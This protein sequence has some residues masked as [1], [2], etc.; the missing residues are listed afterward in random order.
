MTPWRAA[1]VVAL[2]VACGTNAPEI[3]PELLEP[4]PASCGSPYYPEGP[5]GT[6]V[7]EVAADVCFQGWERPGEVTH[8]ADTLTSLSFGRY[9]DP[10][11]ERYELLLVNS[12]ALWCMACQVEHE[13]LPARY[14]EYAPRGVVILSALFQDREGEPA[15]VADLELWVETFDTP[16]PM[17]LDPDYQLGAYASAASAPLNLLLDARSMRIIEKFTGD[18]S[19]VLWRLI[20]DE[21]TRRE[22]E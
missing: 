16:F 3:P 20:E 4:P 6:E 2:L 15:T 14:E 1:P 7:G 18:Q 13:E 11:G 12:A 17:A 5:Y 8:E 9:S 19:T 22:A 10:T 21:L